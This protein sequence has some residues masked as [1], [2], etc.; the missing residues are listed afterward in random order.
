[1][2]LFMIESEHDEIPQFLVRMF[3]TTADAFLINILPVLEH[4]LTVDAT[5]R[6][7]WSRETRSP[8]E[9][10]SCLKRNPNCSSNTWIR[11]RISSRSSLEEPRRVGNVPLGGETSTRLWDIVF[12]LE[13][14]AELLV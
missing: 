13:R 2:L 10:N 9:C 5:G 11:A 7:R 8:M 1:M 3:R 12:D 14:F 4:A 6:P